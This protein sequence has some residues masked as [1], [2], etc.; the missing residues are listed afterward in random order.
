MTALAI[1][2]ILVASSSR[3]RVSRKWRVPDA[4]GS[5]AGSRQIYRVLHKKLRL[6]S[7]YTAGILVSIPAG[8]KRARR[9]GRCAP[10]QFIGLVM[11]LERG[12]RLELATACL[13]GVSLFAL[14]RGGRFSRIQAVFSIFL[15]SESCPVMVT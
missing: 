12:T 1:P 6:D 11:R 9:A 4:A 3:T 8:G 13:E 15:P 10:A 14:W 5:V 2:P 7:F